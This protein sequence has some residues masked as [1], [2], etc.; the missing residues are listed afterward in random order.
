MDR[1]SR[2]VFQQRK[3]KNQKNLARDRANLNE[4]RR[5]LIVCEGEKT[6]P[7]YLKDLYE[8]LGL[9]AIDIEIRG[10]CDSAPKSLVR[11]GKEKLKSDPDFDMV[12]FVFDQDFHDSYAD[13]LN[14]IHQMTK[15]KK[16]SKTTIMPITSIPCFEIWFFLHFGPHNRPY[17]K[18]GGKSPCG[19]LISMLRQK[20]GFSNYQKSDPKYFSQLKGFL[21]QAKINSADTLKRSMDN[22]ELKYYGKSTTLMHILVEELEKMAEENKI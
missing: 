9:T 20:T 12:F 18:E 10:D 6:E 7:L 3:P 4:R 8:S 1:D 2:K 14:S 16:I 19:N 17:I 11:F 13:A 5:A 22:G 21:P 15:Q